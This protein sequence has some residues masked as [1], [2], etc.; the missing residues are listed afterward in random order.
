VA[1][2]SRKKKLNCHQKIGQKPRLGKGE[3]QLQIINDLTIDRICQMNYLTYPSM[4]N[5]WTYKQPQGQLIGILAKS[6]LENIGLIIAEISNLPLKQA[7]I[8][9]FF[10]QPQS[11][12]QGIGLQLMRSLLNYLP[13]ISCQQIEINYQATEL[14]QLALE[15]I[16]A[17]CQWRSPETTFSLLQTDREHII[18][19][20]WLNK[21]S[22]P[23]SFTIFP[24][25]E[26]T[27][28]EQAELTQRN[29]YP[30]SLSP[31]T[32]DTRLENLN[33]LGLRYQGKVVGW[34][35]THR[36]DPQT[37]RYSTMYVE[38]KFQKLGRGI[39]L[40]A[41]AI[42]RQLNQPQIPYFKWSTAADNQPMLRFN[43]RH[44]IPYCTRISESRFSS[45]A[46]KLI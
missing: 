41:E 7:K 32:Q 11:R 33:S 4:E 9:S 19:A 2:R 43:Q 15:P 6:Q 17:R 29:D 18:Q 36:I 40:I 24:W 34:C 5:Y 45:R 8:L 1:N 30:P 27:P 12:H 13:E 25:Q 37:L 20:P 26:L 44:L 39:S 38:P 22:L 21:Y 16:L 31:L 28:S 42:K 10:V 14:T 23:S 46:S 35:L 3:I